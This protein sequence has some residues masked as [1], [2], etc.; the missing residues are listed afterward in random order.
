MFEN[1]KDLLNTNDVAQILG[2]SQQMVRNL[3]KDQKITSI[4]IGREYRITK[5]NLICFVMGD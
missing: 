5:D 3:I 2:V 1:C 4:K